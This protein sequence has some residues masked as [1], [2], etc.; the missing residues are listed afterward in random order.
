MKNFIFCCGKKVLLGGKSCEGRNQPQ[1]YV[2]RGPS[3]HTGNQ[4]GFAGMSAE[5]EEASIAAK[6]PLLV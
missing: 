2:L 4:E 3:A 6:P 1:N 5:G